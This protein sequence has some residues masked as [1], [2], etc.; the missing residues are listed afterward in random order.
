MCLRK[1]SWMHCLSLMPSSCGAW[2][3]ANKLQ[4]IAAMSL[5]TSDII[6][7]IGFINNIRNKIA[8]DLSCEISDQ[9]VT[10]LRNCTPLNIRQAA[11]KA[12]GRTPGPLL[13]HDLLYVVLLMAEVQRQ[14]HEFQ[15][16]TSRKSAIRMRTVL[17]RTPGAVYKK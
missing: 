13:F 3:F 12:K 14:E 6:S 11:E 8:R 10:D 5:L 1:C 17:E 16:I 7:P 4:L 2:G 15:R 9:T